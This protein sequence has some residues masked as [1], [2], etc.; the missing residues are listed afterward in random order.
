MNNQTVAASRIER[1][2]NIFRKMNAWDC[3]KDAKACKEKV[4]QGKNIEFNKN[5]YTLT[6]IRT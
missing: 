6:F 3:C 4:D 2:K 1:E 5:L